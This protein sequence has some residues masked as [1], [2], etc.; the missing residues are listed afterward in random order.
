M[1]SN[2]K[3]IK[4]TTEEKPKAQDVGLSN[5][6]IPHAYIR[7]VK[8]KNKLGWYANAIGSAVFVILHENKKS[9]ITL[10]IDSADTKH[11]KFIKTPFLIDKTDAKILMRAV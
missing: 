9:F 7:I 2:R 11:C 3:K 1:K 8:C 4:K 5:L 6:V 10:R